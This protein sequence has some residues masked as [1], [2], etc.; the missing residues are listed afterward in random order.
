MRSVEPQ[1]SVGNPPTIKKKSL[2]L[3]ILNVHI[4]W[5]ANI[6]QYITDGKCNR[7]GRDT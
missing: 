6:Y 1:K 3:S 7:W 5:P 4:R 2:D